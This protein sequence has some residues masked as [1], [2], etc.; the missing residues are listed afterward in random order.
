MENIR[1]IPGLVLLILMTLFLSG[2]PLH[3]DN[4][5]D[6]TAPEPV[7]EEEDTNNIVLQLNVVDEEGFAIEGATASAANL[8]ILSQSYNENTRLAV[9]VSP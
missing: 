1:N 8:N 2:C 6:N 7:I 3:D 4:D 5:D 9:E